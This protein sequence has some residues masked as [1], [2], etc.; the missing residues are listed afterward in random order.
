MKKE[1]LK[2]KKN[3]ILLFL[4]I[5]YGIYTFLIKE[6]FNIWELIVSIF[7]SLMVYAI[8]IWGYNKS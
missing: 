4:F 2:T 6:S 5:V 3:Y 7:F 8:F 1:F